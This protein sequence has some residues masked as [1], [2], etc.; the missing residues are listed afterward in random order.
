MPLV[1][2][3]VSACRGAGIDRHIC[4]PA[5]MSWGLGVVLLIGGA[6]AVGVTLYSRGGGRWRPA[7]AYFG[8]GLA[9]LE[10]AIIRNV[11]QNAPVIYLLVTALGSVVRD[12]DSLLRQ[13]GGWVG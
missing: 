13:A 2:I 11:F 6:S 12:G 8:I 1:L 4:R 7:D 10:L 5:D 9:L 3:G